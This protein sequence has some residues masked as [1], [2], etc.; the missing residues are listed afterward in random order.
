M[1]KIILNISVALNLL[2]IVAA[3]TFVVRKGGSDYVVS[4]FS[5]PKELPLPYNYYNFKNQYQSYQ[6]ND[7]M[8]IF[9]GNSLTQYCEWHELLKRNDILNRGIGGERTDLL[10]ARL[11]EVTTRNPSK[12]FLEIGINDIIHKVDEKTIIENYETIVYE[13]T[14][15]CKAKVY[16]YAIFPVN[17]DMRSENYPPIDTR[18]I[19]TI[20]SAIQ[21]IAK[22]YSCEY[23]DLR[24]VLTDERG[25]LKAEFTY[26]GLHLNGEG[27]DVWAKFLEKYIQ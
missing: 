17:L 20:N 14:H 8:I 9:L 13:L 6:S 23:L 12:I 7:S 18:K 4:K 10:L 19:S 25:L 1:Q 16:L 11:D 21:S 24:P 27:Y 15:K 26:D 22:E 5:A 3:I 2:L